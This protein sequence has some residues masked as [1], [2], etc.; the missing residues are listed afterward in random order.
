[1]ILRPLRFVALAAGLSAAVSACASVF[2]FEE[3]GDLPDG[4]LDAG[5]HAN[6]D[7]TATLFGT[8]AGD[9]GDAQA[10]PPVS[11]GAA[12]VCVPQAPGGWQG[13]YA[14]IESAGVS[15]LPALLN[16]P[17]TGYSQEVYTGT[18]APIA[19]PAACTCACASP[20]GGACAP[21][22]LNYLMKNGGCSPCAAAVQLDGGC[23]P[24]NYP[25]G[26][27]SM[28]SIGGGTVAASGACAP[29]ASVVVPPAQWGAEAR[30]C[31]VPGAPVVGSCAA[32]QVCAPAAGLSV[33][34]DTYCV[35]INSVSQCPSAY[36][37][38]ARQYYT[39]D[40]DTRGC[41]PC[42]CG[43]ATGSACG[44]SAVYTYSDVG[45]TSAHGTMPAPVACS[46]LAGASAVSFNGG[47]P[48][49]GSCAP[50]GGQP[51]G[52]FAPTN[53]YTICCNQ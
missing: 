39:G 47:A 43:P 41:T 35:A 34:K 25:G 2:G 5:F 9:E 30:L 11:C 28:A 1:M 24:V 46:S 49:G 27:C 21:P 13:P 36:Y 6:A 51:N 50:D 17:T 23:T 19:P 12:A 40:L 38:V 53:P 14:I 31:S 16:C 48:T 22:T 18:G 52:S 45:C 33:K 20:G 44:N 37:A 10:S 32:G 29:D 7:S 4:G 8:D 15:P 26:Q 42:S 3:G